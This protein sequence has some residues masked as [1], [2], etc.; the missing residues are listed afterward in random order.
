MT[1]AS[2]LAASLIAAAPMAQAR[3][4]QNLDDETVRLLANYLASDTPNFRERALKTKE[5]RQANEF[6]KPE[7]LERIEARMRSEYE[8]FADID[9]IKL[10]VRTKIGEFDAAKGVYRIRTFRPGVFFRFGRYSLSLDNASDFY[11]WELPVAEARRIREMSQF[12]N[13]IAEILLRPFG[14]APDDQNQ[15]RTQVIDLK[16]FEERSGQLVHSKLV[17]EAEYRSIEVASS[18]GPTMLPEETVSLLDI[19]PGMAVEE[20]KSI[21]EDAGYRVDGVFGGYRGV[22]YNFSTAPKRQIDYSSLD[23]NNRASGIFG[24]GL[25]CR[26]SD[27][28]HSCGHVRFDRDTNQVISVIL[29]Q[30]AVGTS[31]QDL[32]SA[33]FEKYGPA[34]DR[35]ATTL[36]EE[37][38]VDQY[39]WGGFIEGNR[40]PA[41]DLTPISGPK[42]WQVEAIIAEPD[43]RRKSVIVQIN[44]VEGDSAVTGAGGVRF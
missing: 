21:L 26:D 44:E 38:L 10:R 27:Q 43:T 24:L 32:V 33:L 5:Y 30:N 4:L 39:V 12:G 25:D 7:V 11:E 17:P 20:A 2:L 42:H 1:V 14:V 28:I 19:R 6:D 36:W 41:T 3:I 34:T 16:L 37:H 15:V 9:G 31:K 35:F 40:V 18:T 29:L 8:G 22:H 23:R 13:M